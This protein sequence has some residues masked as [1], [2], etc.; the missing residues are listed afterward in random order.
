M[1]GGCCFLRAA[2]GIGKEAAP[3]D[4]ENRFPAWQSGEAA[5]HARH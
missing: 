3:Q 5:L 4:I 2:E 1:R